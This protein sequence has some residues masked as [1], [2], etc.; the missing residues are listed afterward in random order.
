VVVLGA[1]AGEARLLLPVASSR[2]G[3]PTLPHRVPPIGVVVAEEW[4]SGIA[5]SL[6]AGL[7]E[8]AAR[9]A[10]A[11]VVTLVD[12][13]HLSPRA[14]A[15]VLA[16]SGALRQAVYGEEGGRSPGHPVFIAAEHFRALGEALEGDVGARPYLLAHGVEAVDCTGLG[17]NDDVDVDT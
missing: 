13:P 16:H 6:R 10:S 1:S 7:G 8:A 17:G 12:L 5:T 4:R 15:R 11:A 9:G 3:P 14:V 2:H